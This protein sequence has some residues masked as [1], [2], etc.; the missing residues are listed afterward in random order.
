M[1]VQGLADLS[2]LSSGSLPHLSI[3]LGDCQPSLKRRPTSNFPDDKS[4]DF[5]VNE[6]F[7]L[8]GNLDRE[9]T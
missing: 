6:C 4:D 2:M 7:D 1:K 9:L 3:S 8:M 5:L